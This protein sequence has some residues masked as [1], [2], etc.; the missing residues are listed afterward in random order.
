MNKEDL[1]AAIAAESKFTKVDSAKFLDAYINVV[2]AALKLKDDIRLIG[3]CNLS[4]IDKPART[5]RNPRSGEAITIPASK[6]VKFVAG[7]NLKEAV[8]A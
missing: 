5:G 8:N 2:T 6:A 4:V 7:K 1:I 3:F